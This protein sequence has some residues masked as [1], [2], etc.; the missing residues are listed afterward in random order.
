MRP[1]NFTAK[2]EHYA[3]LAARAAYNAAT[4]ACPDDREQWEK[5]AARY[6]IRAT[7]YHNAARRAA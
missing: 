5:R 1:V 2:A 4:A 7:E 6:D 3:E